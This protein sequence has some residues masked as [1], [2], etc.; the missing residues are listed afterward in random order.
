M[1]AEWWKP[2]RG[3]GSE[4]TRVTAEAEKTAGR[5]PAGGRTHLVGTLVLLVL[6]ALT[7]R[8]PVTVIGPLLDRIQHGLGLTPAV[9]GVL[10]TLPVMCLGAF[11]FLAPR[12]R[13]RW[14]DEKV[15]AGCLVVLLVGNLLRPLGPAW[16]LFSGTV[17]VGAGIAVANVALPGLI[18][19]DFPGRV[20]LVTAVYTMCLTLGGAAAAGVVVPL[21]DAL[22]SPWRMPL[23]LL[24]APVLVSLAVSVWALR[25]RPGTAYA[26]VRVGALWRDRLAW[27]VTAFMGLQS[28]GAYVVFGWLPSMCLSRGMA[29]AVAGIVLG[30]QSALQAAGSLTVPVLCRRARDQRALAA[31]VAGAT[32][33]GFA[34]VLLAPTPVG[35]WASIVVLGLAQGAAFGLALTLFGLRSADSETAAALSGMAQ[36]VGYFIAATGPLVVG[37]LREVSGGWM[38]PL[39]FLLL[40][41]GVEVLAGMFAGRRAHVL[42][43]GR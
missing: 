9:V 27:Q 4:N 39:A 5:T 1:P 34:G 18:K 32:G 7:L 28:L 40:C 26:L 42:R 20:P 16:V 2:G 30:I 3:A 43:E 6:V 36:G 38:A 15:L 24:A 33:A 22:G 23:G 41:A 14:G 29:P 11:A 21:G 35:L 19:R 25:G 12:L 31:L 8:P 10:T 13:L 37:L 17:L